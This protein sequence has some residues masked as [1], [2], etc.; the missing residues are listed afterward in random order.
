MSNT[1]N[2]KSNEGGAIDDSDEFVVE[3]F[4]KEK[5]VTSFDFCFFLH[6]GAT[7]QVY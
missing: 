1:D 5:R 7:R 4:A 6:L 2:V 3:G